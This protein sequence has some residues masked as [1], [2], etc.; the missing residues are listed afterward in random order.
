MKRSIPLIEK[1]ISLFILILIALIFMGVLVSQSNYDLSKYGFS[2]DKL[3]AQG[4]ASKKIDTA[5]I[6]PIDYK[7]FSDEEEYDS[8][9]LYEKI[10]GKAPL[11]LQA[12]FKKLIT[13]R[14]INKRNRNLWFETYFYDMAS[15]KNAYSVFSTQRRPGASYNKNVKY[16]YQ[17]KNSEIFIRNNYYIEIVGS[18]ENTNLLKA[19]N[20]TGNIIRKQLGLLKDIKE[21][22]LLKNRYSDFKSAKY[23]IKNTFGIMNFNKVFSIKYRV[24]SQ[25]ITVFIIETKNEDDQKRIMK[26]FTSFYK[27]EGAKVIRTTLKYK[28]ITLLNYDGSYESIFK[29]GNFIA[30]VHE[31]DSKNLAEKTSQILFDTLKKN[32]ALKN[33]R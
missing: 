21:L 30:G 19:I 28:D 18:K 15:T 3:Q 25:Y 6:L 32:G 5:A 17:T 4:T 2:L 20:G 10:N 29:T 26:T 11:Y 16:G 8:V 24:N 22:F 7:F 23:Y 12:G 27:E 31:A 14:Y 1:I 13:R 9:S 33:E